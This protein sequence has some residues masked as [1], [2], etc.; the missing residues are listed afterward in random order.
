MPDTNNHATLSPASIREFDNMR[1][2]LSRDLNA[3][4]RDA[5]GPADYLFTTPRA[6]L[7]EVRRRVD[8]VLRQADA[9]PGE[10]RSAETEALLDISAALETEANCRDL[11]TAEPVDRTGNLSYN[12]PDDTHATMQGYLAERVAYHEARLADPDYLDRAT[13]DHL[14]ASVQCRRHLV[15][16][17]F[18]AYKRRLQVVPCAKTQTELGEQVHQ[19]LTGWVLATQGGELPGV[20]CADGRAEWLAPTV[21]EHLAEQSEYLREAV[22]T[23][24]HHRH[25]HAVGQD[26][27]LYPS[28]LLDEHRPEWDAAARVVDGAVDRSLHRPAGINFDLRVPAGDSPS[29]GTPSRDAYLRARK[30]AGAVGVALADPCMRRALIL[31]QLQQDHA[32]IADSLPE[33]YEASRRPPVWRTRQRSE[34]LRHQGTAAA[35]A[36]NAEWQQQIR[37]E[38]GPDHEQIIGRAV[39]LAEMR[40]EILGRTPELQ[41]NAIEEEISNEPEWL[42]QT[43]GPRPERAATRWQAL[44]GQMAAN[45]MHSQIIDATDPGIRPEQSHLLQRIAEFRADA[46]LVRAADMTP[47]F[48][49]GM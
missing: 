31:N 3:R 19:R 27:S 28:H 5:G 47:G 17:Q 48:G 7:D 18:D 32:H 30:Q 16:Q 38:L 24:R 35:L 12:L 43:L 34:W 39:A 25:G 45:R 11:L 8:A 20:G 49:L 37:D 40:E 10:E 41:R 15:A 29:S 6:E 26:R 21:T 46:K 22:I 1:R 4:A 42:I 36:A 9:L 44:A 33:G 23:Y 14:G 2:S 13:F